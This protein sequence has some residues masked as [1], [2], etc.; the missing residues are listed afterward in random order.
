MTASDIQY[1]CLPGN[2]VPAETVEQISALFSAHYG[3]WSLHG[4]RSGPVKMGP[5]GIRKLLGGEHTSASLAFYGC[6][7]IA[8]AL[9]TR[10]EVPGAGGI[11][12]V[13]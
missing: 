11:T 12:W 13:T 3:S 5:A 6:E 2:K 7:L 4:G 9:S 1:E 8:H 10:V